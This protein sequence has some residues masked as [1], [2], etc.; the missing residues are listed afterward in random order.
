MKKYWPQKTEKTNASF[1]QMQRYF[2]SYANE[3]N[4]SPKKE[5]EGSNYA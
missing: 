4:G 5:G 1:H 3:A 2:V